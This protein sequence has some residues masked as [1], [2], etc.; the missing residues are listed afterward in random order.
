[1]PPPPNACQSGYD[2]YYKTEPGVYAYWALCEAGA[3]PALYDYLGEYDFDSAHCAWGNGTLTGG[4]PGPVKDGETALETSAA[5]K[6]SKVAQN[7]PIN[8][9]AGT[10]ALWINSK[11]VPGNGFVTVPFSIAAY[12][13]HSTISAMV[14]AAKGQ[15][16]FGGAWQNSASTSFTSITNGNISDP[17][18]KC[19]FAADTWHRLV[20]TWTEGQFNI[21]IDGVIAD[22]KSYSGTLDN[23]IYIYQLFP[24]NNGI[25]ADI[26]K[27]AISN[28]AWSTTQVAL[29]YWPTLPA[30]TDG[31]VH[32]AYQYLGTIHRDVLGF[33]D[34]NA[35]LS[36]STSI[37]ALKQGLQAAGVTSVR[38]A[39]GFG[40]ISADWED[41]HAG[42]TLA[43]TST[44]GKTQS[45]QNTSSKNN[46]D[47]YMAN[48]AQ[49]LKLHVGFTVNY[50]TNPPL[51]NAPGDPVR[52]G[53]DLVTYANK[54]KRYGVKYWE[55]GNEQYSPDTESDNHPNP[56]TGASYAEYE[57]AFYNAMKSVDPSISIAVPVAVGNFN[58]LNAWSLPVLA[59]A[60]Y[61]D[62]VFHNYPIYGTTVT[63][64]TTLYQDRV[65]A[66][67]TR[68]RANLLT[69]QTL[70][71]NAGKRQDAIW[72]TEWNGDRN[73]GGPWSKQSM[74]AVMPIFA[75]I[76]L[77]EYMR[78]GVQYATWW[79]QGTAATCT[80]LYYDSYGESAYSWWE[81]GGLPLA[82]AGKLW[83]DTSVGL[84]PGDITPVARA[85][86]LLSQSGFVTE[87]EHMLKTSI[88]SQNSPWLAAYA[89]TH[90]K[91]YAAI[92]INR[93]RDNSHTVP[94]TLPNMTSG[95]SVQQ[96]TYG[97]AQ[98]DATQSGNWEVGP[99]T[100]VQGAWSGSFKATLPPWSVNVL[101]F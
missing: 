61:D 62:V 95:T 33:A 78:A 11:T 21:Y 2:D 1:V 91:T 9:N 64:G 63:D 29:D 96:W 80:T 14:T 22:S 4:L 59:G 13:A 24:V 70:L 68:S 73:G 43:C 45:A 79:T 5:S 16:C 89:A 36:S 48:V 37:S 51:C 92:L 100:S 44:V 42:S 18:A 15:L 82:Y 35:D 90:G 71:L 60:S 54:V 101:I 19:G 58:W 39:N 94:V 10:I 41:W 66:T 17:A 34:N 7:L 56:N 74:G 81:C 75:T 83:G 65:A 76:Q 31:G 12:G 85:F 23:V 77:A 49:P 97:R 72:V 26:A 55:I 6:G 28:Q 50:A 40:G 25:T 38:Y 57:P 52:N 69:L 98:Y 99:V 32:V 27:I 3:N 8:R 93:D 84:Q 53:A 20:L 47:N 46:L 87:N 30:L 67:I 88:D 86:Q